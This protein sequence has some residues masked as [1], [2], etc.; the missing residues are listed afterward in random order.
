MLITKL[1]LTD[2]AYIFLGIPD[3]IIKYPRIY[4]LELIGDLLVQRQLQS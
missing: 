1:S 2:F 4:I 3:Y